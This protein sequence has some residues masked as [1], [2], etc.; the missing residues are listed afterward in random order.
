MWPEYITEITRVVRPRSII[1]RTKKKP[2]TTNNDTHYPVHYIT[3]YDI[4]TISLG[5]LYSMCSLFR[6]FKQLCC[7]LWAAFGI[8]VLCALY[9]RSWPLSQTHAL[10]L[11][12]CVSFYLIINN[13]FCFGLSSRIMKFYTALKKSPCAIGLIYCVA[14]K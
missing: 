7:D 13:Q 12:G 9:C 10:I 8:T 3:N 4:K 11:V 14:I 2:I 5:R 6:F 1:R